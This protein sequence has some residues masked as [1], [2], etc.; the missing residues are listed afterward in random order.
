M[1][2]TTGTAAS[3]GGAG[4][5]TAKPAALPVPEPVEEDDEFED[6]Q[7]DSA[8]RPPRTHAAMM[9]T[10]A[11]LPPARLPPRNSDPIVQLGARRRSR[12]PT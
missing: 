5:A 7:E 2:A 9:A 3:T 4:T 10:A 6:F 12:R 8:C 1:S 11:A